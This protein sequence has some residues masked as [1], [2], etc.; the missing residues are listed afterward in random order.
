MTKKTHSPELIA[1]LER[2]IK[3]DLGDGDYSSLACIK[4]DARGKAKVLL[5]QKGVVAGLE[6]IEPIF[7]LVDPTC[8]VMLLAMD[9]LL[10]NEGTVLARVEGNVLGLLSGERVM[11]NLLQRMSGIATKTF[12]LQQLV[13]PFGTKILDT[14]KTVP[15]LRHFDQQAVQ[16]GGGKNHRIGLYDMIMIKDNHIDHAGGIP[17]AIENCERY[18]KKQNLDLKIEVE[19]RNMDE[20]LTIMEYPSVF[21]ILLDNF[22][23]QELERAVRFIGGNKETEAS[24]GITE[25]TITDYA[26]TGVNYISIGALTHSVKSLDISF[27]KI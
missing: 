16:I 14:R 8:K 7:K 12:Y 22:K 26:R 13:A 15:G 1:D 25:I 10:Y 11:L 20:V 2:F 17:Q 24:G 18:I 19:A 6:Y 9:G 27:K 4:P 3:E 23:P 21:R 5:K